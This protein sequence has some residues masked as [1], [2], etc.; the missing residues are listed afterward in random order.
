LHSCL[1]KKQAKADIKTRFGFA[2]KQRR[3]EL[4]LSQEALAERAGLHRT[5][6]ADIERGARNLS[7]AN[8]E[9]LAKA[10]QVSI[11]DL[12]AKYGVE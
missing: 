4:S 10:L 5:Y 1:I 12:F 11:S 7:L 6:V 8:I 3:Q 9:K 2:V